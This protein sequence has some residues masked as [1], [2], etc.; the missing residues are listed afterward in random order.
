MTTPGGE[1]A[2]HRAEAE[3][4]EQRHGDDAGGEQRHH[5]RE[6]IGGNRGFH[7]PP[8]KAIGF[9]ALLSEMAAA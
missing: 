1:I 4:L 7:S 3:A 8:R 5:L 6:V 9:A 2:Q